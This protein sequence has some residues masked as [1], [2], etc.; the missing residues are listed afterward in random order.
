MVLHLRLNGEVELVSLAD[1]VKKSIFEK[2]GEL[3]KILSQETI[4]Y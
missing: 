1:N 4:K 2:N 3:K